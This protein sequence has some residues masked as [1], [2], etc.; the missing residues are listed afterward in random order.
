MGSFYAILGG[1]VLLIDVFF[2]VP[3]YGREKICAYA[4]RLVNRL[5]ANHVLQ[6]SYNLVKK[7]AFRGIYPT[8]LMNINGITTV[9]T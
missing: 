1:F 3:F 6:F 2:G 9:F 8:L 7:L 4:I 5:D